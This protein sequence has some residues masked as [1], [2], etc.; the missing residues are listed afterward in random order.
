MTQGGPLSAKLF[1][2]LIDT[3]V[4]E[5]LHQLHDGG[6]VDSEELTTLANSKISSLY[7]GCVG[8]G[9]LGSSWMLRRHFQDIHPKDLVTAP[10]E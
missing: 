3:V 4:R 10:K 5:W 6:I 1:N 8:V 2:I 9:E 7:P